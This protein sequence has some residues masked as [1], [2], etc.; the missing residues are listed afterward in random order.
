MIGETIIKR[1][2]TNIIIVNNIL[3]IIRIIFYSL[4]GNI[5]NSIKNFSKTIFFEYFI[6][7]ADLIFTA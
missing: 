4:P 1:V 2:K 6:K 7:R 3:F 5:Q